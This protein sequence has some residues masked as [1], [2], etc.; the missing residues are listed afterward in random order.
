MVETLN[1]WTAFLDSNTNLDDVYFDFEKAFD[2]VCH[3]EL[4]LKLSHMGF[5]VE[6]SAG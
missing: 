3:N 5:T 6:L 2:R 4:L 1:D